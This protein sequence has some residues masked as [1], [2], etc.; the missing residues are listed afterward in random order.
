MARQPRSAS[1]SPG[2]RA[3]TRRPFPE[4]ALGPW[5]TVPAWRRSAELELQPAVR[6]E[7]REQPAVSE[8]EL[9]KSELPEQPELFTAGAVAD[10]AADRAGAV[11]AEERTA[12]RWQC[13]RWGRI[14][15]WR[16]AAS[17]SGS[18]VQWRRS[19]FRS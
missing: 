13:L 1:R 12:V 19:R 11:N 4:L 2:R 5:A 15:W 9:S 3:A 6:A 7:V 8:P 10:R 14:Q 16:R 17:G 18:A